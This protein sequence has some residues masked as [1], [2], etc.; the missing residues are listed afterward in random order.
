MIID[1]DRVVIGIDMI[2]LIST[3]FI[4]VFFLFLCLPSILSAFCFEY[5]LYGSI[6]SFFSISVILFS[7]FLVVALE[8]P[9]YLIVT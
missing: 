9:Y 8:L 7:L 1:I 6:F 4:T 3:I 5:V 2:R